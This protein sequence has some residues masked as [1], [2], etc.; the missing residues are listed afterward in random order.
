MKKAFSLSLFISLF[1]LLNINISSRPTHL[2]NS[3]NFTDNQQINFDPKIDIV[4][5]DPKN[6]WFIENETPNGNLFYNTIYGD[7]IVD[8]PMIIELIKSPEM[9]RLKKINQYGIDYYTYKPEVYTRFQHSIC[10]YLLTKQYGG[11]IKEQVAALLHDVS[12]TIFSHSGDFLLKPDM[13]HD[14][15]QDDI[16]LCFLQNSSI[17]KILEKYDFTV[18]DVI[19]KNSEFKILDQN[20]PELC[21]D[22]L[23]YN[24][25]GGCVEEI[26]SP[27][28][29]KAILHDLRYE[30]GY[31][32][33]ND[34]SL[35]K[36][37]AEFAL[38]LTD[39]RLAGFD[40]FARNSIFSDLLKHALDINLITFEDIH[41][42]T[43]DVVWNRFVNCNDSIINSKIRQ[44]KNIGKFYELN[45]NDYDICIYPKFRA[46]NPLIKT[47]TGFLRLT[48]LNEEFKNKYE[49]LKVRIAQGIYIKFK[50]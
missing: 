18:N 32:Y 46:I 25:Y 36:L 48:D 8:D 2:N 23:E 45:E 31:W 43:D 28:Q 6:V 27:S 17:K 13:R 1:I 35:A 15:Y 7:F 5:S 30:N 19:H 40:N 41:L 20:V 47:E 12:H 3:I 42:L 14:S 37:L 11:S 34:I 22:R 49:S 50:N 38:F 10:V 29:V 24:L 9:Q 39:S 16:H 21:A 44:L 33:F 4:L 26:L